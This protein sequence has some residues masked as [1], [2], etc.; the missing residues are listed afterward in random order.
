MMQQ[1]HFRPHPS[2][3]FGL[4][5]IQDTG[6]PLTGDQMR[7]MLRPPLARFLRP[8]ISFN[9]SR[10]GRKSTTLVRSTVV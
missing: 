8:A 9:L 10:M 2:N 3:G 1:A 5:L 4:I 7:V 6:I